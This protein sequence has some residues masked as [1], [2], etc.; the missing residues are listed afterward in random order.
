MAVSFCL[1]LHNL[2]SMPF[3][4]LDDA[5]WV[6][7]VQKSVQYSSFLVELKSHPK[8]TQR[9]LHGDGDRKHSFYPSMLP[10]FE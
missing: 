3:D 1:Y 10:K 4:R 7:E 9:F 6:K 8:R 5:R 2:I